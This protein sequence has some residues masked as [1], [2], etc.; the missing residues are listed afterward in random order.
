MFEAVTDQAPGLSRAEID[1]FW[2]DG[3]LVVDDIFTQGEVDDL[4]AA[5]ESPVITEP[6]EERG[7]ATQTVHLLEVVARHPAFLKLARDPRI[8]S[9]LKPLI[10]ENI[11]LQHS[12]LATQ[13][14]KAGKGGFGWH[15]DFAFFP[16]TNTDLIAVMVMLD[17]ATPENGCMSMVR[18]SY[19]LG[20]LD[21]VEDGYFSS[22]CQ[23]K[24][25]WEEHPERV[26]P[27]TPRAG[28]ISIH[29][30]LTVHGSGPNISGAPRR[31]VVFQYRADDAFQMADNVWEDTGLVIC[32][33][34][35]GKVRCDGGPFLLPFRSG[36]NPYCNAW[37]QEGPMAR[38]E[39][40]RGL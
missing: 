33:A 22:R 36:D 7:V 8:V 18:G 28:G 12:K 21:H 5:C 25:H 32:G 14:K 35:Q 4:R 26:T 24:R 34:K 19:K 11:Q 9:R 37:Y 6:C 20:L 38:A 27:I 31:G 15:Q 40:A 2:E 16:H 39:N 10:G 1:R 17:D 23:E 3:F 29:H 30:C 13:A